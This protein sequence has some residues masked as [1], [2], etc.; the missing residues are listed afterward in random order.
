[1]K[2]HSQMDEAR[3]VSPEGCTVHV[4]SDGPLYIVGDLRV[5]FPGSDKPLVET[6]VAFCRCGASNNKPF[7]DNTHDEIGFEDKLEHVDTAN[8]VDGESGFESGAITV[9][10]FQNGPL[11][12]DGLVEIRC[13]D[14]DDGTHR[15]VRPTLCRCGASKNKPFCDGMHKR[16]NFTA[17]GF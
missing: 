17:E 16:N 9:T 10:P 8:A 11:L 14:S 13:G 15:F 2:D 1:M 4:N 3:E 6:R 7:C 5:R 12:L